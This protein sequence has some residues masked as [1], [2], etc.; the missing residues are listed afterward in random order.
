MLSNNEQAYAVIDTDGRVLCRMLS[1]SASQAYLRRYNRIVENG[2]MRVKE[3][4]LPGV[5]MA[6]AC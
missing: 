3:A 2:A 4:S 6:G 5:V 1:D